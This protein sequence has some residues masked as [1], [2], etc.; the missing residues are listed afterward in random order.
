MLALI[1]VTGQHENLYL[2]VT[3]NKLSQ[4]PLES[5][6]AFWLLGQKA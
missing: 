1:F 6:Y 3:G 4:I 5:Q 2:W